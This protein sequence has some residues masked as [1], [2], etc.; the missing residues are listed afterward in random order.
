MF[1]KRYIMDNGLGIVA[2]TV[3][4]IHQILSSASKLATGLRR[5]KL[6]GLKWEDLDLERGNLRGRRQ[7][8]RING[9]VVEAQLKIKNA[10]RTLPLAEDTVS[11]RFEQT[12]K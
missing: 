3:R 7:I 10:C 8:S 5:G 6:L 2:K 1:K 11:V 12:K 9:E 4:N